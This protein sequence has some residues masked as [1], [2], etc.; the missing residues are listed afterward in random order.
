MKNSTFGPGCYSPVSTS[1]DR[2]ALT[3]VNGIDLQ[4][5]QLK[6]PSLDGDITDKMKSLHGPHRADPVLLFWQ[7]PWLRPARMRGRGESASSSSERGSCRHP[8]LT[9][10]G[11]CGPWPAP[12]RCRW[13]SLCSAANSKRGEQLRSD[14]EQTKCFTHHLPTPSLHLPTGP[15]QKPSGTP[16]TLLSYR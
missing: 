9:W 15:E 10:H 16:C 6:E 4:P 3:V 14:R 13:H 12:G 8:S 11:C 5:I 7:V 1:R 2:W